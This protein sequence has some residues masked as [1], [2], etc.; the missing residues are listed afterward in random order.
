MSVS[1]VFGPAFTFFKSPAELESYCNFITGSWTRA[2]QFADLL[3]FVE[4]MAHAGMPH[5]SDMVTHGLWAQRNGCDDFGNPSRT[6]LYFCENM[7]EA[8]RFGH[9]PYSLQL[10]RKPWGSFVF[11]DTVTAAEVRAGGLH[12]QGGSKRLW[13][14]FAPQEVFLVMLFL[15][16]R[17]VINDLRVF[18][19]YRRK[20]LD[21]PPPPV[22]VD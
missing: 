18:F 5:V 20:F 17:R 10:I 15:F 16:P 3:D 19:A 6:D 14:K 12:L 21:Q 7:F 2:D 11:R 13:P 9:D 1:N 22:L 8:G 4:K